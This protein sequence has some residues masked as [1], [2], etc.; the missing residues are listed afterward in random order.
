MVSRLAVRLKAEELA[1]GSRD[2]QNQRLTA[3]LPGPFSGTASLDR[4][5]KKLRKRFLETPNCANAATSEF[6]PSEN[7]SVVSSRA[8]GLRKF[9]KT[10]LHVFSIT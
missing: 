7:F 8:Y 3:Q 1:T 6:P 10:T 4:L 9:M 5:L 2:E